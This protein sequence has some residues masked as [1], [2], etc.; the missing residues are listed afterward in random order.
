MYTVTL[1]C[2]L[3]LERFELQDVV[4]LLLTLLHL[5]IGLL[6]LAGN[7]AQLAPNLRWGYS[8][9]SSFIYESK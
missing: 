4:I 2:H 8:P 5:P 7:L 1:W 9:V 3:F 6:Q